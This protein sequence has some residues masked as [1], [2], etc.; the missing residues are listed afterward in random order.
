M[1][2]SY[3][4]VAESQAHSKDHF[5]LRDQLQ[6]QIEY[7]F[8][9]QN[10]AKDTFLRSQM[11]GD[12]YVLVSLIAGFNCVRRLTQ[13]LNL[14][15]DAIRGRRGAL[16]CFTLYTVVLFFKEGLNGNGSRLTAVSF[17]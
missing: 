13:D 5:L 7:Y 1:F 15:T 3:G 11:D 10:L 16:L 4:L 17:V 2:E 12:H 14:I 9:P 6:Q 8:S